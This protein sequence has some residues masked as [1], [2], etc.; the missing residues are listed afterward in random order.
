MQMHFT[1]GVIL[2]TRLDVHFR[3]V[4]VTIRRASSTPCKGAVGVEDKTLGSHIS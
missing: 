2:H 1:R 3:G 4:G